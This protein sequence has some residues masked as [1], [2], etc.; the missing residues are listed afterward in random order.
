MK[1]INM[2]NQ[3]LF[4]VYTE[5]ELYFLDVLAKDANLELRIAWVLLRAFSFCTR[6]I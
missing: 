4:P 3:F 6:F 5:N 2:Y 1:N